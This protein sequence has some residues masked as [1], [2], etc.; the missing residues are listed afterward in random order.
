MRPWR[1]GRFLVAL[2]AV[3]AVLSAEAS[4][5]DDEAVEE[6][7]ATPPRLSFIEGR[8]S[9]R[10]DTER[11]WSPAR[12][13]WPLA[14]GDLLAAEADGVF[15]LEIGPDSFVRG[16]AG[17]RLALEALEADRTRLRAWQGQCAFDIS[18]L[19]P[20]QLLEIETPTA[21]FTIDRP[22]Y[23]RFRIEGD[24]TEITVRRKG[25]ARVATLSGEE[26]AVA[27][28]QQAVIDGADGR[29]AA[30]GFAPPRDRW[31]DWNFERSAYLHGAASARYVPRGVYG[32]RDLDRYGAW[33]T[34][35]EY[36]PIWVPRGIPP[37]W[38]PYSEGVWVQDPWYGWTWVDA[39]PWGWAPF[40]YGRWVF[41]RSRWCWAPGPLVV[42]PVYA[43]A[44]VAF[45]GSG[46]YFSG[47]FSSGTRVGWVA[48]GWGEPCVPWWGRPGFA[49]RP[50]WGGWGGPRYIN[51]RPVPPH[52]R[53][54]IEDIREYRHA[55]RPGGIITAPADQFRHGRPA[56][57]RF[58]RGD[59]RE[60]RPVPA[61]FP[62]GPRRIEKPQGGPPSDRPDRQDFD[63]T[64]RPNAPEPDRAGE[65]DRGR[66]E[67]PGR[68]EQPGERRIQPVRPRPMIESGTTPEALKEPPV[69]RRI[70]PLRREPADEGTL[71]APDRPRREERR[72][73]E[74]FAPREAVPGATAPPPERRLR[75][76]SDEPPRRQPDSRRLPPWE[77]RP[78]PRPDGPDGPERLERRPQMPA[79]DSY[80]PGARP[81][82]PERPTVLPA[83]V[84]GAGLPGGE[85]RRGP[86]GIAP[87]LLEGQRP[88]GHL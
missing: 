14:P 61:A 7:G 36:G 11:G 32:T 60:F 62:E 58:G 77:G 24:R 81:A 17:S 1:I 75:P 3:G 33:E 15:E 6:I 68:I 13:N 47:T 48:L 23:Y 9:V 83:P 88:G 29:G 66:P 72:R 59:A 10:R 73:E 44:L 86:R 4:E 25:L 71:P 67:R 39:A 56:E 80:T 12:V 54:R 74:R 22:G 64:R 65:F 43:P 38:V 20:G 76:P 51:H 49:H 69:E 16:W 57:G 21:D 18:G 31:D 2:L 19:D 84:P 27:A 78:I 42:R 30:I 53:V 79:A 52:A 41:V 34:E 8:V 37:G 40:H 46:P 50:W 63:R 87:G 28:E 82:R 55:G 35:P 26:L 70:Q 45:Y 5:Y 85:T